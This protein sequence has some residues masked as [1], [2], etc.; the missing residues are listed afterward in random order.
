MRERLGVSFRNSQEMLSTVDQIPE[1]CGPWVTKHLSFIDSPN[2][3]FTIRHRNPVEAL[4]GL[5]GDPAFAKHLVYKPA[6]MFHNA[7]QR[8]RDR[9]Y[10]EMWTGSLWNTIQVGLFDCIL[11]TD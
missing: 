3:Y 5:W 8:R 9:I 7:D 2:E 6:K 10:N 1:R 4:R 11:T